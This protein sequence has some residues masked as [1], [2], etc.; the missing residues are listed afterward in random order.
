MGFLRNIFCVLTL[1]LVSFFCAMSQNVTIVIGDYFGAVGDT[2]CVD[3][4]V[5]NFN[6]VSSMEWRTRFDPSILNMLDLDLTASALNGGPDGDFLSLG[7]FNVYQGDNGYL[8]IAWA[9]GPPEGVTLNDGDLLY[10]VCFEV[11]GEPCETSVLATTGNPNEITITAVDDITGADFTLDRDEI[12]IVD[13]VFTVLP[14][15]MVISTSHCSSDDDGT[16]GAVTFAGAGGV[17]PYSWTLMGSGVNE[18]GTGLGDCETAT[19]NNLGPGTYTLILT[20][21]NGVNRNESITIVEN[22]SFPFILTLEGTNPTC[23]D[24]E[25]GSIVIESIVGGEGA[26][27]YAWSNQ[28][29]LDDNLDDL[30]IGEYSLTITDENGCSTS[31]STTLVADTVKV[32]F[33]IISQPSCDGTSDGL[34]TLTAVGGTPYSN[35]GYDFDVDACDSFYLGNGFMVPTFS[36]GNLFEECYQVTVQ[37]SLNC[38]SDPI[39]FCLEAG[40]FSTLVIDTTDVSCFGECDGSVFLTAALIGNFSFQV[41]DELGNPLVGISSN[42]TYEANNVCP[43][44]YNA[45]VTDNSDGCFVDTTFTIGT[46]EELVVV[47]DSVGPGCSGNDGMITFNTSGGTMPYTYTWNDAFDQPT[48]D[49]MAGGSYS[50]TIED[51]NG[52]RDSVMWTFAEGGSIGLNAGVLNAVNCESDADGSVI[53]TVSSSGVFTFSWED[54]DG[55]SLGEGEQITNLGGGFYYVTATDGEC[56]GT[57][58]V[59]L[60]PG[61][62]PAA[63]VVMQPPSCINTTDGMLT[64]TL[65]EGFSPAMFEWSQPPSAAI[66]SN[67]PIVIGGV[68][69][70]NLHITDANGCEFDTLFQIG[71][72]TDLIQI[73]IANLTSN[74]CFGSCSASATFTASGGPGG[75]GDYTFVLNGNAIPATGGVLNANTLCGGENYILAF[76][77]L[78]SSD[79]T[80]FNVADATEIMIDEDASTINPP[81]CDGNTD[82]SIT[83]QAMG[84]NS[85]SYDYFWVNQGVSSNSLLGLGQGQYIL[86]IT[87]GDGCIQRDTIDLFTPD[88]LTVG[89]LAIQEIGCFSESGSI[90]LFTSGGN[91]GNL[92]F[93]WTPNVSTTSSASN[94][95]PGIYN[96]VVTDVNGCSDDISIELTS[97]PPIVPVIPTP[98]EPNCFGEQTCVEVESVSGGIGSSYSFS[99][100]SGG[101]RFPIDSCVGVFADTITITVFDSTGCFVDT[102]L[103]IDQPS[104][105]SVDVGDDIEID[106]GTDSDPVSA[107]IVSEFDIDSISWTPDIA[108]ECNTVDCQIVT[109]SPNETTSYTITVTDENGCL[110]TDDITVLVDLARNVY[111]PNIFSPNLDNVNDVFQL[112][113]GNGVLQVNY[114]KIFDRWGNMVYSDDNYIPNDMENVG[115][116]GTLNG[117]ESEAGVYVF[118]AEVAFV[119]GA[120][121]V[122]KGDVTLVR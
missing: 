76:D 55:V 31:A 34:V 53:A 20:D 91:P 4:T 2:V 19:V 80:F 120:V 5:E 61:T 35:G 39:K 108:I 105:L 48:R 43:G 6:S 63:T 87:D 77:I 78:C 13:G 101:I 118:F 47:V 73:D 3:V 57:D 17:G 84:G 16:S 54:S 115:W 71:P 94:L 12:D 74:P 70:Y 109:F 86:E 10:T 110:A 96:I 23:F 83:V 69:E 58:S 59:F 36:P 68:G 46:P 82:G 32:S 62:T 97:A 93:E 21:S 8:T 75:T 41:S 79:T 45:I 64:A 40:S 117:A 33:E 95:A 106:L 67:G 107:F 42:T 112:A 65:S 11:I 22:S 81:S 103:I 27:T 89:I 113:V 114:L 50:V 7:D 122:Y 26:F 30:E 111:T 25:N 51:F 92:D 29:F 99:I 44:T 9:N 28:N 56:M 116:D 104:Q 121:V 49:N 14:D 66:I 100:A 119:D 18:S 60:A 15:G 72:P 90:S 1:T 37:D 24:K 85:S 52:C 88:P 38:E 102:T 98:A